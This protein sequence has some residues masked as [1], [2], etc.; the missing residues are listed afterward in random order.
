MTWLHDYFCYFLH[1][2]WGFLI[3]LSAHREADTWGIIQTSNCC[4]LQVFLKSKS[5]STIHQ[6][7]II[8]GLTK[9]FFCL[10]I[11]TTSKAQT[12]YN[13]FTLMI[14]L[15]ISFC[16]HGDFRFSSMFVVSVTRG[17]DVKVRMTSSERLPSH[18]YAVWLH[19]IIRLSELR[20][21]SVV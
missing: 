6:K 18:R 12:T 1:A 9:Y 5:K 2:W 20:V 4:L 16:S 15:Y 19:A 21:T 14:F 3:F 8:L 17:K 10:V 11:K 13:V 7:R